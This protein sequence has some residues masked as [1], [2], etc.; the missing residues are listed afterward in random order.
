MAITSISTRRIVHQRRPH[1][2]PARH[3]PAERSPA[4][5]EPVLAP[6]YAPWATESLPIVPVEYAELIRHYLQNERGFK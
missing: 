1:L 5:A 2:H 4:G 3:P 6:I